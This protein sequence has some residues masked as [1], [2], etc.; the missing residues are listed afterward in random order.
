ME[1]ETPVQCIE[2]N[3]QVPGVSHFNQDHVALLPKDESKF[4]K[5]IPLILES[6]TLDCV[7][8]NL[9]ESKSFL[10]SRQKVPG[11]RVSCPQ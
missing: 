7:V 5:K 11:T 9:E 8:E 1:L 6:R 4:A 10:H 2:F 3:L